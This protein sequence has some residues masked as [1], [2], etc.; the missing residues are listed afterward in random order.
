MQGQPGRRDGGDD[1]PFEL[2]DVPREWAPWLA[3]VRQNIRQHINPPAALGSGNR[4]LAGK[5]SVEVHKWALQEP[6]NRD[7]A[8][9]AQS[10]ASYTTDMGVELGLA[11]FVV[12]ANGVEGLL[13]SWV[14]RRD[15]PE[16]AEIEAQV[17]DGLGFGMSWDSRVDTVVRVSPRSA[18]GV[19]KGPS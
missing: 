3:T 4:G 16:A 14:H 15:A 8:L 18:Q 12:P 6:F 1:V 9:H 5:A 19:R 7:L 2:R 10:Y 11:D 13:P 17:L